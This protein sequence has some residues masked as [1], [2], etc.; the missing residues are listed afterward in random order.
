ME[1]GLEKSIA[2]MRNIANSNTSTQK[3]KKE[4]SAIPK[5]GNPQTLKHSLNDNNSV[6]HFDDNGN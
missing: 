6:L 3:V 2:K 1:D 4:S 5:F